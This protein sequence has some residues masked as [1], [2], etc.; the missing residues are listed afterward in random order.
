MHNH[1]TR[2]T[3]CACRCLPAQIA[4]IL[5]LAFTSIA[6]AQ[7][8]NFNSGIDPHWTQY[9]PLDPYG[10]VTTFTNS[11]GAYQITTYGSV[12]AQYGAGPD[13]AASFRPDVN[14]SDF[15]VMVDL[16]GWNTSHS[17]P[18]GLLTRV[19]NPGLGTTNGYALTY[20]TTGNTLDLTLVT[21]EQTSSLKSAPVTTNASVLRLLFTGVGSALTGEIFDASNLA[22]PLATVA[23]TDGT[24][25]GG[26]NGLVIYDNSS[27]GG[28]GATGTF[29]NYAAAPSLSDLVPEPSSLTCLAC[30][31][32]L[33]LRRRR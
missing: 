31:G 26:I 13:R 21:G 23:T 24:Y 10:T 4:A 27:S 32:V 5:T 28:E 17:Q 33:L 19:T 9:A 2:A 18:L 7:R 30:A 14:Y 15:A 11:S 6:M 29:D 3:T 22:T 20:D 12:P 8:D 25:G 1:Q 16:V